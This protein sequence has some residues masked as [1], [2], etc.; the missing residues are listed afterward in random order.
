MKFQF[1]NVLNKILTAGLI[2]KWEQDLQR[3]S[4]VTVRTFEEHVYS[5]DDFG[6]IVFYLS[7][8]LVGSIAAF[9]AEFVVYYRFHSE[10]SAGRRHYIN[11]FWDLCDKFIC[12]KRHY[13]L[14]DRSQ[15]QIQAR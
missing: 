6:V 11:L 3:R 10:S 4:N 15:Q 1:V 5:M 2:V 7:L 8:I 12:G 13:F 9:I 14:L